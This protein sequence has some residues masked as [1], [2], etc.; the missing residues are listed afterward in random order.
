[1]SSDDKK[2]FID[3]MKSLLLLKQK[4]AST[5]PKERPGT[6]AKSIAPRG[7]RQAAEG[8]STEVERAGE[9]EA[10]SALELRDRVVVMLLFNQVV[11]IEHVEAA[12]KT[13]RQLQQE[14]GEAPALWR[15]LAAHPE[16][17]R[18]AAFEETARVYAFEKMETGRYNAL[19]FVR[20]H[21]NAFSGAQWQRL[22]E[23]G[24]APVKRTQGERPTWTFAT[25]DPT[26]AD[27]G[28]LLEALGVERY[29]L[30]YAPETLVGELLR[31]VLPERDQSPAVSPYAGVLHR[32]LQ[33]EEDAATPAET[34]SEDHAEA[35]QETEPPALEERTSPLLVFFEEILVAAK[36][37]D[38]YARL[39][40]PKRRAAHRNPV[41][42]G[43]GGAA[44]ARRAR[45]AGRVRDDV[46][47]ERRHAGP[48][49]GAGDLAKG[50]ASAVD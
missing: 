50:A 1:M 41:Q 4:A 15:V 23:A 16:V 35:E 12:W 25:H 49:V 10:F 8:A 5:P 37:A 7:E 31:E 20:A 19:A 27:I 30:R 9:P 34:S 21:R 17:D 47:Q 33:R 39:R 28:A 45:P 38:R 44:V 32:V 29:T 36:K 11:Q 3:R 43:G 40:L 18:E 24:L 13:W 42:H 48:P 46:S 22:A 26:Q 6:S 14:G 2:S